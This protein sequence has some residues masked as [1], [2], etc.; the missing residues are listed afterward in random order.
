M[1]LCIV[2]RGPRGPSGVMTICLSLAVVII[3]RKA[4][5]P[6]CLVDPRTLEIPTILRMPAMYEPSW[7]RLTSADEQA[8]RPAKIGTMMESC[9]TQYRNRS[10][11]DAT[12]GLVLA[13]FVRKSR[14]RVQKSSCTSR[15]KVAT[16]SFVR[17]GLRIFKASP[18]VSR[19]YQSS[20]AP[21]GENA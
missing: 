15:V 1:P 14:R 12:Y 2:R 3:R 7:C 10:G 5:A 21:A 6:Q 19:H 11:P 9:H 18:S 16:A 13:V 4:L 20:Y 17:S 8:C